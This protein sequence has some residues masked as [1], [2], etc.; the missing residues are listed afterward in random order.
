MGA[1]AVA[2]GTRAA[3]TAHEL[4]AF[5]RLAEDPHFG[6]TARRLGVA[7]SSLSETIRRLEAKLEV[8]L[9]ERSSRHVALTAA[10]AERLGP[11]RAALE[12]LSA[13]C[14]GAPD[15]DPDPAE[16]R[17]GIEGHGFAELN[18]PIFAAWTAR[19]PALPLVLGECPGLPQAF[20]TGRFD[21]A[22]MRS[23]LADERLA[24]HPVA[25]EPRGLVVP[26]GH[27]AAG[28]DSA[29]VLDFLD[30]PFIALAPSVPATCDYW[31]GRELRGGEP[32]HIGGEASTVSEALFGIAHRSLVTLGCPSAARAF[33]LAG[34]AF[35][36]LT[37]VDPNT[38][39][40]VTRACD[41][42][43]L[44]AELVDLVRAVVWESAGTAAEIAPLTDV[45]R[46]AAERPG[47]APR[48]REASAL[49]MSHVDGNRSEARLRSW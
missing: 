34:I 43:P 8:V 33:P 1:A 6:R 39:S 9:F 4:C 20:L 28:A 42:R 48:D 17:V 26:A 49:A 46:P 47:L 5:V 13:V 35:V 3:P 38:L 23:P 18:R 7:Q 31:L 37:D 16:L 25:S 45:A 15:P 29:S 41:E 30:E 24:V 2:E 10:G 21:V 14:A 44:I 36:G 12:G 11:A 27:P 40:V 32:A 22:L 19:R